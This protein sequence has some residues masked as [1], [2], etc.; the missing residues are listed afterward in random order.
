MILFFIK[1]LSTTHIKVRKYLKATGI[2]LEPEGKGINALYIQIYWEVK[3]SLN[4]KRRRA[5]HPWTA[6]KSTAL[7]T[8]VRRRENTAHA[9]SIKIIILHRLK[10]PSDRERIEFQKT[11]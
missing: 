11:P 1:Q 5:T 8:Q 10:A 7:S 9:I 4:N 6:A 3:N 2:I